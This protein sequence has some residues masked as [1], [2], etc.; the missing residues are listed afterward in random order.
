MKTKT[1]IAIVFA[2]ISTTLIS[3][4]WLSRKKTSHDKIKTIIGKW[5]IDSINDNSR[6]S[7]LITG[8]KFFKASRSPKETLPANV[9]FR[10]NSSYEIIYP[11]RKQGQQWL[12]F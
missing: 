7:D 1:L 2:A 5:R 4:D 10:K 8:F 11:I 6:I 3:C 9:E 12:L